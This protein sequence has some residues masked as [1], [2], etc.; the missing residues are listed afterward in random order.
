MLQNDEKA[1][2]KACQCRQDTG[3]QLS[4]LQRLGFV[5]VTGSQKDTE[6]IQYSD[7][8][9]IN[10]Q[11]YCAEEGIVQLEIDTCRCKQH[12]E[13]MGCRTQDS[14][15]RDGKYRA[16]AYKHSQDYEYYCLKHHIIP[17][18]KIILNEPCHTQRFQI[19]SRILS[20]H[21][22]RH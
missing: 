20:R 13:K 4:L 15:C 5:T 18:L 3:N 12:K 22:G 6:H 7:T 21:A 9:C 1:Q 19:P 2:G 11:L 17:C 14:L 10:Q 16:Y 8:A